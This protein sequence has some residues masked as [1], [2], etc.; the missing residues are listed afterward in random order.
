M[1]TDTFER[2]IKKLRVSITDRCNLN[3]IYCKPKNNKSITT[4]KDQEVGELFSICQNLVDFG[5]EELR[6]TGGEPSTHPEFLSFMKNLSTLNLK[7]LAVTTNGVLIE[8][9]LPDLVGIAHAINFSLDGLTAESYKNSTGSNAFERVI[10]SVLKARDLGFKVKINCVAMKGVNDHQI[11]DFVEFAAKNKIEIR[12]L[13][14]MKIGIARKIY[15]ESFISSSEILARIEKSWK[16]SPIIGSGDS[17]SYNYYV[18]NG[19]NIG[20]IAS[21]TRPFCK[22][23]S[24]LRLDKDGNIW[25]C[26][27]SNKYT[28]V[29]GLSKDELEEVLRFK[30]L[31]NR[32]QV[33]SAETNNSMTLL[34]G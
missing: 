32:T 34:G 3:C 5:I 24:R 7:K 13:E 1:L 23:C 33:R 10:S 8:K 17:T 19:A 18:E 25:P 2:K 26:L 30:I 29:M 9:F 31:N 20:F 12:F 4:P 27:L 14:L 22:N 28:N 21:E 16:V 15:G 11:E 6:I